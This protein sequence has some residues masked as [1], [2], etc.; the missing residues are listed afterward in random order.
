M[1]NKINFKQ[2]TQ[3]GDWK[4]VKAM[5]G[6]NGRVRID[7]RRRFHRADEQNNY[8][9]WLSVGYVNHIRREEGLCRIQESN[10]FE[11]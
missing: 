6:R 3:S 9:E 11:Y 5:Q 2:I 4:V 10:V 1:A 8:S 7:A